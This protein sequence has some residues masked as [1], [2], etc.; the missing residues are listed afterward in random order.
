M[1]CSKNLSHSSPTLCH[2]QCC[3]AE[4]YDIE[5]KQHSN[6]QERPSCVKA[7]YSYLPLCFE[8]MNDP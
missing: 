2:S 5:I 1:C 3:E 8:Y 6:Y 4:L 7:T